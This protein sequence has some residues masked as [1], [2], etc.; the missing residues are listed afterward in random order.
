MIL[1][2][3]MQSGIRSNHCSSGRAGPPRWRPARLAA[4]I[5]V[6]LALASCGGDPEP[7][8]G[9][10][11]PLAAGADPRRLA[12]VCP[13]PVVVQTSWYPEST[14][15]GLFQLWAGEL[16]V[17]K[18]HKR[19]DRS[20]RQPRFRHR[21]LNWRSGPAAPA[22]GNV[23]VAQRIDHRQDPSSSG[24]RPPKTRSLAGASKH[25]DRCGD[26]AV[27][28]RPAG[29]HLGQGSAIRSSTAL[30]DVGQTTT[31]VLT[32]RSEQTSITC[33]VRESSGRARSTT[34]TTG[35]PHD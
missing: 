11:E 32:F 30:Q 17:D 21:G 35:R 28:R 14:H 7:A 23:P 12:G 34:A 13:D 27:R 20:T 6:G 5:A 19:V 29:V 22:V 24:N 4:A 8:G 2:R 3:P 1:I 33:S 26:R 18:G 10:A 15:G 31:K 9:P 25:A 16:R